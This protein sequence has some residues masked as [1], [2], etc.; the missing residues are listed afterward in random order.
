MELTE[1]PDVLTVKEIAAYL[2][3]DYQVIRSLILMGRIPAFKV[4]KQWRISKESL[5]GYINRGETQA[6]KPV[7]N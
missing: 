6:S 7:A 4:G 3:A 5:S 1:L 2:R